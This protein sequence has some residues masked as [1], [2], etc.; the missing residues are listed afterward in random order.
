MLPLN[1]WTAIL[2]KPL[3]IGALKFALLPFLVLS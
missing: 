1:Q 3:D 2:F